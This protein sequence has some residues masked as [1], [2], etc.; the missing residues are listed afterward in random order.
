MGLGN[1]GGIVAVFSMLVSSG[2][3]VFAPAPAIAQPADEAYVLADGVADV[4]FGGNGIPEPVPVP[5]PQTPGTDNVDI[6]E[7]GIAGEDELGLDVYLRLVRLSLDP[8]QAALNYCNRYWVIADLEGT[9]ASH[10]FSWTLCIDAYLGPQ[11]GVTEVGFS[12]QFVRNIDS[13]TSY[14]SQA[15]VAN[16]FVNWPEGRL[17]ARISKDALRGLAPLNGTAAIAPATIDRGDALVAI[18]VSTQGGGLVPYFDEAPDG[19]TADPYT[20]RM[21]TA[22]RIIAASLQAAGGVPTQFPDGTPVLGDL[23]AAEP[24]RET[25]VPITIINRN[26]ATRLI[27]LSV[28]MDDKSTENDWHPQIVPVV[29]VPAKEARVVNLVVNASA[30]LPYRAQAVAKVR[31]ASVGFPDEV[32]AAR[33]HILAGAPPGPERS[34]L[35]FHSRRPSLPQGVCVPQAECNHFF[36]KQWINAAQVDGLANQ[37]EG[38]PWECSTVGVVIQRDGTASCGY[39]F[40]A[41]MPLLAPLLLNS[42]RPIRSSLLFRADQPFSVDVTLVVATMNGTLLAEGFAQGMVG[43]PIEMEA[44]VLE[45]AEEIERSEGG[46]LVGISLRVNLVGGGATALRDS[47]VF[48]LDESEMNF[49]FIIDPNATLVAAPALAAAFNFHAEGER[50]TFVNPGETALF[51]LTLINEGSLDGDVEVTGALSDADWSFDVRPA[52]RFRLKPGESVRLGI[53]VSAPKAALEGERA[54]LV[55]NATGIGTGMAT[56]QIRLD[57]IATSASDFN[58][59]SDDFVIDNADDGKILG[60]DAPGKTPGPTI[61]LGL[62]AL[63]V[64]GLAFRRRRRG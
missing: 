46:I 28:I 19:D 36:G 14:E 52:A 23:V 50:Q 5:L 47:F 2:M 64:A 33:I 61:V 41:D 55:L 21:P 8:A 59:Q 53:L 16:G 24:G 38:L 58:D 7:F 9:T 51:N 22:N 48:V 17:E 34:T 56:S 63:V 37:D 18:Q 44:S 54:Q 3:F 39:G 29:E 30:A 1:R 11:T 40:G 12:F 26:D 45:G 49:P 6:V 57:L 20:F 25:L 4:R 42:S 62:G 27:N 35:Y 31:G 10:A 13:P 43:A 15:Q 60:T 32:A